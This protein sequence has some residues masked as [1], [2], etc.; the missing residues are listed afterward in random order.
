MY[1][2]EGRKGRRNRKQENFATGGRENG[3]DAGTETCSRFRVYQARS[4]VPLNRLCIEYNTW[5][6]AGA[7]VY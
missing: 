4:G 6:G 2:G 5:L 3:K 1:R 7:G